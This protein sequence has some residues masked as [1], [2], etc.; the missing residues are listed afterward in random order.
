MSRTTGMYSIQKSSQAFKLDLDRNRWHWEPQREVE[1]LSHSHRQQSPC[2]RRRVS[3]QVLLVPQDYS[4]P[5]SKIP[6]PFCLPEGLIWQARLVKPVSDLT[7][8]VFQGPD[9]RSAVCLGQPN[10]HLVSHPSQRVI[11]WAPIWSHLSM[12]RQL[13]VHIWR[14]NR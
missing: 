13:D 8:P 5:L 10:I 7:K 6:R 12:H 4:G 9:R 11:S 3:T 14:Q 1:P 2:L